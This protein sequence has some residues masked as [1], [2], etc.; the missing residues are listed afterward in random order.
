MGELIHLNYNYDKNLLL[1]E[2]EKARLNAKPWEGG[3]NYK[4]DKW[5]VSY[6]NSEYIKK[7]MND[8]N[9]QGKPRFFYQQPNF[10]LMP[11]KDFG[12]MCSVN[13]ILSDNPEPIIFKEKTFYYTQ[14]LINVQKIHSV[15]TLNTE[16]I[17]LKISIPDKSFD[18]VSKEINYVVP[19]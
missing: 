16:R 2:S 17:M 19:S 8:L 6:Y 13:I 15:K 18:E 7:I 1:Q 14:A 12:T 4:I 11:H 9:I 5:L 3:N 10:H